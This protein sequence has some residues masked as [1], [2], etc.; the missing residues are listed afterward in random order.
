MK[1]IHF[2][3]GGP[4]LDPFVEGTY[5]LSTRDE[6]FDNKLEFVGG[7]EYRPLEGLQFLVKNPYIE[8]L[9]RIA[10]SSA[11]AQ[12]V[13]FKGN[14]EGPTYDWI[15]KASLYKDW[16]WSQPFDEE[17]RNSLD[18][19]LWGELFF[20]G[21]WR[22]TS[23]TRDDFE[24]FGLETTGWLGVKF[25]WVGNIPPLMPYVKLEF[26]TSEE[27]DFF[28]NRFLAFA[29]IRYMPFHISRFKGYE[30]L[31]GFKLFAEVGDATYYDEEPPDD[32]PDWDFR[33]GIKVDL[34]RF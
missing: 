13:G 11:Y 4:S 30:W 31:Y 3:E 25:P 14:L 29:G 27:Q 2:Y 1:G 19:Y 20:S 9:Q 12:I 26:T 21:G 7:L 33:I 10:L 15:N 23:Y 5:S 34:N 24:S 32:R 6:P 22:K 18:H 16:G 28:R 8:W 17:E